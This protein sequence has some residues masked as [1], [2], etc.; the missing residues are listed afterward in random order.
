LGWPIDIAELDP[1]YPRAAEI[2]GIVDNFDRA[3]WAQE[4]GV[5][6]TTISTVDILD[7]TS[8]IGPSVR[9]AEEFRQP[10]DRSEAVQCFLNSS[11]VAFREAEDEAR[12]EA[13]EL[14]GLDGRQFEI[15]AKKFVLACGGIE[16]ARLLLNSTGKNPQGVGNSHD[17]VGRYFADHRIVRLG[18]AEVRAGDLGLSRDDGWRVDGGMTVLSHYQTSRAAGDDRGIGRAILRLNPRP[19]GQ[20]PSLLSKGL[21][22][23]LPGWFSDRG[24][25][26]EIR[27]FEI[28][29]FSEPFPEPENRI[30]LND[31]VDELGLRRVTLRY[32]PSSSEDDALYGA[33]E[34]FG[35]AVAVNRSGVVTRTYEAENRDDFRID[36]RHH[37]Y[38]RPE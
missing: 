34:I 25:L 15:A 14:R 35:G 21:E 6:R 1:Y 23:L 31:D 3:A 5:D 2:C 17:Q 8:L 19:D 18:T 37:H 32:N 11:C 9:F 13:V 30:V 24:S 22:R 36:F 4:L 10:I 26:D 7:E 38:T 27:A 29:G 20:Q 16:N 28:I 33:V 12:V